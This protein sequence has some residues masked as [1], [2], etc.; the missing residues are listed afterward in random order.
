MW[1]GRNTSRTSAWSDGRGRRASSDNRQ[2]L[3]DS[4]PLAV[5]VTQTALKLSSR[6][7]TDSVN[8][9]D[10]AIGRVRPPVSTLA[11]EPSDLCLYILHVKHVYGSRPLVAGD[12]KSRSRAMLRARVS[13]DCN[14]V[15]LTSILNRRHFLSSC[16]K[17]WTMTSISFNILYLSLWHSAAEQPVSVQM[18]DWSASEACRQFNYRSRLLLP[19][20]KL[21]SNKCIG[22]PAAR[23]K[24]MLAAFATGAAHGESLRTYTDTTLT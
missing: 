22:P 17:P 19:W 4:A 10:T 5:A 7:I 23:L 11:I 20:I 8:R 24:R 3:V 9:Q 15:G 16:Q 6:L 21:L 2:Q 14:A 18:S 12:W 1:I 13:N